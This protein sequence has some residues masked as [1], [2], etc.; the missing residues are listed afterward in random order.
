[1]TI[2]DAWQD[3]SIKTW[4]TC[5]NVSYICV[6]AQLH[7]DVCGFSSLVTDFDKTYEDLHMKTNEW[8]DRTFIPFLKLLYHT[9]QRSTQIMTS[10]KSYPIFMDM[11]Y[12][13]EAWRK[14]VWP[15]INLVIQPKSPHIVTLL[16]DG[17]H[18][19]V[20]EMF[21]DK[22]QFVIYDG[23]NVKGT[24]MTSWSK[25]ITHIVTIIGAV[26]IR[27]KGEGHIICCFVDDRSV[28]IYV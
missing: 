28:L 9:H 19:A 6:K 18:F 12:P 2:E 11:I 1:M 7:F 25:H 14:G 10:I 16:F 15:M 5:N 21:L 24:K 17:N 13:F 27:G 8:F 4:E 23:L 3:K 22:C 26:P 20:L